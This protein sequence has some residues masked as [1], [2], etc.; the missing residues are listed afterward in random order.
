M[1]ALRSYRLDY[2]DRGCLAAS[3]RAHGCSN[4]PT[5]EL[6]GR[7]CMQPETVRR[8]L[9]WLLERYPICRSTVRSLARSRR[10][11]EDLHYVVHD[12][13][14]VAALF[15][16]VDL[17]EQGES[18][19]HALRQQI[20]DRFLD[21]LAGFP[22][23]VTLAARG[24]AFHLFVQQHHA[25]ADGRAFIELLGR[26]ARFLEHAAT[27][28]QPDAA[29]LEPVPKRSELDA[30]EIGRARA[31]AWGFAGLASWLA[32][33]IRSA[34]RPATP[35]FQNASK[36]Y[37]GGNATAFLW[38]DAKLRGACR[39]LRERHGIGL[40]TLVT[41][42]F[43]RAVQRWNLE[44][45]VR[46]GRTL[47]SMVAEVRPRGERFRS[48][49]NHL[50]GLYAELRLDRDLPA[51]EHMRSLQAQVERQ[52]RSLAHKK[53]LVFERS[54]TRRIPLEIMRQAIFESGA[55][56]ANL[57][58]SNLLALPFPTLA[59]ERWSIEEVRIT[60]P[61]A[62]PFGVLFTMLE[63]GGRWCFNFNHKLSIVSEAQAAA[64]SA[65]FEEELAEILG[66]LAR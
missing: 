25:I 32:L 1:S 33:G 24:D 48:F 35:Q 38:L 44:L 36:D 5:W 11:P 28:T 65:R 60:T 37:S 18:A 30:L 53:R 59:G 13:Y 15:A 34:A 41:V 47:L 43:A 61:T 42:A 49:A 45:G 19:L 50:G 57:T 12:E 27:G 51:L 56:S 4:S 64:L 58:V 46:C 39:T 7:G 55:V 14:D 21:P 16:S 3:S 62:P 52:Q 63:Y 2:M 23:H 8:A 54:A 20:R 66:A 22:F 10:A 9:A 17:G 6:V 31:L 29:E 40:N 26:F